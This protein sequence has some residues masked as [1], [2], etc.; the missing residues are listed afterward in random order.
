MEHFIK[1]DA[2]QFIKKKKS[3]F[4]QSIDINDVNSF[5]SKIKEE[6]SKSLENF[7]YLPDIEN[8][9]TKNFVI[10]KLIEYG[11]KV[12][13]KI[14]SETLLVPFVKEYSIPI[15]LTGE[16]STSGK[17]SCNAESKLQ[18]FQGNDYT[19]NSNYNNRQIDKKRNNSLGYTNSSSKFD[20]ESG[21]E[22]KASLKIHN[23]SYKIIRVKTKKTLISWG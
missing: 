9:V 15:V 1:F 17:E 6:I 11:F 19:V 5:L 23:P 3:T 14:V 10:E 22:L 20:S 4:N 2:K 12:E 13:D 16:V 18:G 21:I 7:I 8:E